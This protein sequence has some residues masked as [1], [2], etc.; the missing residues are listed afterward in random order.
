MQKF[1]IEYHRS[2]GVG[3]TVTSLIYGQ[4]RGVK[5][6]VISKAQINYGYFKRLIIEFEGGY[7]ATI[8]QKYLVYWN[9]WVE[10]DGK[11]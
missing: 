10:S 1:S 7:K 3:D 2:I 4:H 8:E 5:G 6:R 11:I 9:D